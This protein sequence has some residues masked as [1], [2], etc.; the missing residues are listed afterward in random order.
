MPPAGDPIPRFEFA[1]ATRIVFGAGVSRELGML[2]RDYGTRVLLVTGRHPERAQSG[3]DALRAAGLRVNTLPVPGEPTVEL[4]ATGAALARSHGCDVIVGWGGGSAIDAAKAIAGLVPNSED[5]LEHLE[6]IG[7]A[8]P[9]EHPPLPWIA[10]PTTSGAGAE[11]TRNA[12][13][14][15]PVHQFKASLRSP[16]L[17]ARAALVDP[18]LT[19]GL[20]PGVTAST[21][22]DALTQLIEPFLCLRANPIVDAFCRDGIRR[23]ARAL[24]TAVLDGGNL[25]AR[26]EL[27]MAALLGGLA[28]ANA[29]L[30]SVHGLAAPIGGTYPEAPHGA[31]C[32]ALLPHAL[33][34]NLAALRS[35]QPDSSILP[36]F[37]ELGVLLNGNGEATAEDAIQA[38]FDLTRDTGIRPLREL[39]LTRESFPELATKAASASSMK[40]NPIAL[41]QAEIIGL[42]E[43]AW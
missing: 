10:V 35:R 18:A 32:A 17:L 40:A 27:S 14:T 29:G 25:P 28:L 19:L 31:V 8:R 39:G 11:V 12:V 38:V 41:T 26:T 36:R 23:S 30:G 7:R 24:R 21:G 5:P 2:A 13:L 9:L 43:A 22:L 34:T 16:L 6:V 1:T 4:A 37:E 15:S 3:I 33:R 42:L 20:P